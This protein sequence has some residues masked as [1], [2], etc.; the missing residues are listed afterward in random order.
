MPMQRHRARLVNDVAP[1]EDTLFATRAPN[2][3]PTPPPCP[4]AAARRQPRKLAV[5]TG[6]TD[7]RVPP[8]HL[9][10]HHH[11]RKTRLQTA[12]NSDYGDLLK[13]YLLPPPLWGHK[14]TPNPQVRASAKIG[15]TRISQNLTRIRRALLHLPWSRLR[16]A[17]L[18]RDSPVCRSVERLCRSERAQRHAN[19]QARGVLASGVCKTA[20]GHRSPRIRRRARNIARPK[21]SY[22]ALIVHAPVGAFHGSRP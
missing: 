19:C 11:G 21:E 15:L 17:S 20:L 4:G 18:R 8:E 12:G 9:K 13:V 1:P 5:S 7:P 14:R 6:S 2:H 22:D 10:Y 16:A 3:R